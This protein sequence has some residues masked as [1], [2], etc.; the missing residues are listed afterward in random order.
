MLIGI[1][2]ARKC[3][4]NEP[5]IGAN[6]CVVPEGYVVIVTPPTPEDIKCH[7]LLSLLSAN[8]DSVDNVCD[9]STVDGKLIYHFHFYYRTPF[10]FDEACLDHFVDFEGHNIPAGAAMTW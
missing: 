1:A 6:P 9:H 7:N 4:Y 5:P 8:D 2:S 3:G 10:V